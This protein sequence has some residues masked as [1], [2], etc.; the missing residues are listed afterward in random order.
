VDVEIRFRD[1]NNLEHTVKNTLQLQQGS[2]GNSTFRAG[3]AAG[4]GFAANSGTSGAQNRNSNPL[5]FILGR[6]TGTTS[7]GI[8]P[9][10]LIAGGVVVIVVGYFAY[11][12]F[13]KGKK[14]PFLQH[15]PP[16]QGNE[17]EAK[18]G[19]KQK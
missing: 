11:R 2:G 16:A 12:K 14:L 15:Q 4:T 10:F 17:A 8:N 3:G 9:V 5:S 6:S 13:R 1:S 7:S 18:I 19:R